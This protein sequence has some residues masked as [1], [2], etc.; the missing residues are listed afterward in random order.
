MSD[1][2]SVN[3]IQLSYKRPKMASEMQQVNGSA[4]AYQI[5][6]GQWDENRIDLVEEFKIIL[7]NRASRVIGIYHVSSGTTSAAIVDLKLI[8]VAALKT[9]A[10][11]I[12]MAH[13]HPTG[14]L[15]PSEQDVILTE[16]I[17]AAGELLEITVHDH[18]IVSSDGYYS[19][20][21][22]TAYPRVSQQ[23]KIS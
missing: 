18:I 8:F 13:N 7:L 21:D 16:R 4:S 9:N 3:E 10:S 6:Y 1:P 17:K 2:L 5:L 14:N 23:Y 19:F 15:E 20:A 12:I 22:E 11:S